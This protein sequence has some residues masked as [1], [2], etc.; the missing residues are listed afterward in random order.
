MIE[1]GRQSFGTSSHFFPSQWCLSWIWHLPLELKSNRLP[2]CHRASPST[3]RHESVKSTDADRLM[4]I[5][6]GVNCIFRPP[7]TER[8]RGS[9][10]DSS[11]YIWIAL[12]RR[13]CSYPSSSRRLF[14]FDN[15]CRTPRAVADWD[16]E[17]KQIRPTRMT[18]V[19][20]PPW[21]FHRRL[22]SRG[23]VAIAVIGLSGCAVHYSNR[24]T[25]VEHLWGLGQLRLEKESA[26]M[27]SNWAAVTSGYRVPGLCLSV[28][29]DHF[30]FTLGYL[31]RQRMAVVSTNQ[32]SD[33]Q[34]PTNS[35]AGLSW[36]EVNSRWAFG[37]LR[38]RGVGSPH[39]HWAIVTG[40][41]LAGLG[42]GVGGGDTSV[43]VALD[44]RQL[45]V[46]QDEN[47][48]LEFDQDAPRWP[49]F[50]LFATQVQASSPN[51]LK[52]NHREGAP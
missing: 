52:P 3:T 36:R 13:W 8:R 38:M 26:G 42:A 50:N 23:F 10:C 4:L 29:R 20:L 48:H 43:S 14:P 47:V 39:R 16:A 17:M 9:V 40:K 7:F 12:A 1:K 51:H 45:A 6:S 46:V 49:G 32:I 5:L 34:L 22:L 41:A 15:N 30:G 44:S 37:H 28:G 27:T 18:A 33:L 24:Q 35:V 19:R 21:G 31:D 11:F 2:W 25:G